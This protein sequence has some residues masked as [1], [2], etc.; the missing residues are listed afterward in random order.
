MPAHLIDHVKIEAWTIC[1]QAATEAAADAC[2]WARK[3]GFAALLRLRGWRLK[4][5]PHALRLSRQDNTFHPCDLHT[6]LANCWEFF[7]FAPWTHLDISFPGEM[8]LRYIVTHRPM[9]LDD[10]LRMIAELHEAGFRS[11]PPAWRK[12]APLAAQILAASGF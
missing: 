2:E 5:D 8:Q 3:G 12:V 6:P 1:Q 11:F 4:T 9:H 7:Y 10:T